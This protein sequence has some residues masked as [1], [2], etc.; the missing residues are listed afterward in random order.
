MILGGAAEAMI[1]AVD[2]E[3]DP[4]ERR[5]I[6]VMIEKQLSTPDAYPLSLNALVVGANQ[7]T[8]REPVM[9]LFEWQV[10][11]ALA[12]L[13]E[14]KWATYVEGGRVRRWKHRLDERLM[15]TPTRLAVM[16]ELLLRGS[17]Q[18]AELRRNAERLARIPTEADVQAVLDDLA[19]RTPPLVKCIGRAPRERDVRWSQ[20]LAPDT[21]A[22]VAAGTAGTAP[23]TAV[24]NAPAA[25]PA[26]V[27]ASSQSAGPAH[28]HAPV[29]AS[30]SPSR[31][32]T[33]PP[34]VQA[35]VPAPTP[36]LR[37]IVARI[38]APERTVAELKTKLGE[39]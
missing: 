1:R 9:A 28:D 13:L 15:L 22:D 36:D 8:C 25:G 6:G 35:H 24:P 27:P 26:A 34:A 38:E 29:A 7:K 18:P 21:L 32:A 11:G 10:E 4:T 14:K 31:A 2:A 5:L 3:L 17:Q 12:S 30:V 39:S 23:T 16:A 37:Q 33:P 20:M 19:A